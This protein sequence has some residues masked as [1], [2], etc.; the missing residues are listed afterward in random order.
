MGV[1]GAF[2]PDNAAPKITG[3]YNPLHHVKMAILWVEVGDMKFEWVK[4]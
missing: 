4:L 3:T 1:P 2:A